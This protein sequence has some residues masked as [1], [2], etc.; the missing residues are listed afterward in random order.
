VRPPLGLR[1]WNTLS[2]ISPL[3]TPLYLIQVLE[4][5]GH[6]GAPGGR[7]E[8]PTLQRMDPALMRGLTEY[9]LTRPELRGAGLGE[10]AI[11]RLYR[12]LYVYTIGFFD[13]MQVS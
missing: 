12:G 6:R 8:P 5:R 10:D 4:P 2:Q 9:G 3:L 7:P 13:L 1:P 11:D